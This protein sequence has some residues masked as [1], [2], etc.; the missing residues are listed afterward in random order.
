MSRLLRRM[1]HGVILLVLVI[2]SRPDSVLPST[3]A[4]IQGEVV[5]VTLGIPGT[6]DWALV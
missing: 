4:P 5:T 3:S 2:L 1:L 6:M